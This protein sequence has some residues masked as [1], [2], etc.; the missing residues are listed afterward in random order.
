MGDRI[1]LFRTKLGQLLGRGKGQA[2]DLPDLQR[3][4]GGRCELILEIGANDGTD[5]LRLRSIFP[6]AAIHCFEPDPRA[7]K[8]LSRRTHGKNLSVYE[9]A[10][11]GVDGEIDFFQSSGS[12]PGEV[13][14]RPGGWDYS[15]SIR[16]PMQHLEAYPWCK[17]ETVIQVPIAKLDTWTYQN[18]IVHIDFIWA[19]VQGAEIDLICGASESLKRTRFLY[20]E[21][22]DQELY[23]GQI[24]LDGLMSALP[25]WSIERKFLGDVLLRNNQITK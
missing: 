23:A 7:F 12:P 15:G 11:G 20:T 18:G 8:E 24:G 22:S 3:L 10:I 1:D 4:L 9:L 21:F 16:T 2:I 5:S 6:D 14:V 17:F 13:T 25:G 19:D